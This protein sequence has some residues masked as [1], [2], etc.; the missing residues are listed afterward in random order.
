VPWTWSAQIV[1]LHAVSVAL[2]VATS[3]S[4]W[5]LFAHGAASANVTAQSISPLP[6]TLAVAVLLPGTLQPLHAVAAIVV[7][8]AVVT[9]LSGSYTSSD[10]CAR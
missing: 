2:L 4:I 9:A 10:E 3:L 1:V 7:V 6:A 5:D 8:L